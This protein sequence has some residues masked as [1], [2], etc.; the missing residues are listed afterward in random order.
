MQ[1]ASRTEVNL[2]S[3]WN[4]SQCQHHDSALVLSTVKHST[5]KHCCTPVE[6]TVKEG[7]T[8]EG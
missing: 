5:V 8:N 6:E 2:S 4:S 3:M 7:L 1:I